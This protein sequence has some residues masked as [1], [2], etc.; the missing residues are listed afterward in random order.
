MNGPTVDR[1]RVTVDEIAIGD[2]PEAWR[3]VGFTLDPAT[4]TVVI[5]SVRLRLVGSDG[6]RGMHGWALRG[7]AADTSDVDGIPTLAS[8]RAAPEPQTHP[9]GALNIDHVVLLTGDGERT[10]TAFSAVSGMEVRRIREADI[11]GQPM[12]QRFFRL[13]EVVLEI[14]SPGGADAAPASFYGLGITVADLDALPARYGDALGAVRPA[15]Q[16]GRRVAVLKHR[17]VG[18]SV[19]LIFM[20]PEPPRA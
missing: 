18:M 17:R 5:G 6:E 9:C 10:A 14:V 16:P 12:S 8:T 20:T 19:P 15:V 2:P 11:G 3:E 13:G 1:A 4:D 7:I